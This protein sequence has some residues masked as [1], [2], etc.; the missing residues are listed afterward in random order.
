MD[1]ISIIILG[2]VQ[3]VTEW[4]PLSSKTMDTIVYTQF[5]R[6]DNA[7][8][9]PLLLYLHIGTMV[10]AA[11]FFRKEIFQLAAKLFTE[12]KNIRRHAD[13][14]IGFLVTALAFTGIVG[15]PILLAEKYVLPNL[16]AGAL[17]SVMGAGMIATGFMLTVQRKSRWRNY[18]T[19]S[20]KDG[21]L[22]GV[23]QGLAALPGVSRAGATTTALVWRGFDA[24][25]AF[26]LSFLLSIP[27]VFCTEVVFWLAQGGI[28]TIP[29]PEGLLLAVSSFIF[30]YL[31]ISVLTKVAHKI[32]VASLAFLFGIMMLA[33]GLFGLG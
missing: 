15:L 16:D 5:F 28:S 22:T 2:F 26:H 24:E 27:T 4:L 25:S 10:A 30:G 8:V 14:K 11:I 29:I 1:I 31:T 7:T 23:L 12:R 13:S 20:W 3:A 18:E 32:N 19:A 9:L 6:G 33:F 21:V 17:F